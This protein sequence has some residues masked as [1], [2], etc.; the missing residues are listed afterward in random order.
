[1]LNIKTRDVVK[2][3]IKTLDKSSV[4][5]QRMKSAYVSLKDKAQNSVDSDE[6]DMEEYADNRV[7]K[8]TDG[9]A[10]KSLIAFEKVGEKV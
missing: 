6:L 10:D 7:K 2:G 9:I 8:I 5:A 1:M 3:T 4:A